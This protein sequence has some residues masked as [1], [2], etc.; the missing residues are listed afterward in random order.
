MSVQELPANSTMKDLMD[1]MGFGS[2]RWGSPFG[3]YSK[4]ELRPSLNH[5][6]V[7]H[8][9][10]KLEMGDVVQLTPALPKE[11]LTEY[12]ERIRRMYDRGISSPVTGRG[13]RN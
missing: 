6:P 5:E 1:R 13:W 12:R 3:L 4:E 8:I 11:W 10:C 7:A 2:S 9:L